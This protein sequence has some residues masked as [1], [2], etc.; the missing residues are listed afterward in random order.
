MSA[1]SVRFADASLRERLKARAAIEGR[2][3]SVLAERL[4]EEGLREAAHPNIV[5]R[6]GPTGRRPTLL[7]G[8]EVVD[9]IGA[10]VGGDVPIEDRRRRDAETHAPVVAGALSGGGADV[11]AV[12]ASDLLRGVSDAE[13][14]ALAS[15]QGRALVTENVRDF[16]LLHHQWVGQ[17]RSHGG[18]VMTNPRKFDR[19]RLSYPGN[20][21]EALTQFLRETG[22]QGEAWIHWL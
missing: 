1:V 17:G 9:V 15:A 2:S 10:M 13:L 21:I 18:L 7:A 3:I 4:I 19:V 5:F 12:A 6:D 11:Q 22:G 8:P 14:L 20:L 16:M